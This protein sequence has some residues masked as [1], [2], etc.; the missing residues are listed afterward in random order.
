MTDIAARTQMQ[1]VHV[2]YPLAPEHAF[3]KQLMQFLT[4]IK[5]YW[6][7]VSNPKILLL[8]LWCQSCVGIVLTIKSTT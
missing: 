7:K 2:D 8:F 4:F 5:H 3:L 6:Y 1:V